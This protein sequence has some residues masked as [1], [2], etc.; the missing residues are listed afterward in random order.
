MLFFFS[1]ISRYD[2]FLQICRRAKEKDNFFFNRFLIA[3][4]YA[5]LARFPLAPR[6]ID[7]IP[8]KWIIPWRDVVSKKKNTDNRVANPF[9]F[10]HP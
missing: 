10:P 9:E 8:D 1:W 2:F 3:I 4:Y 7:P 6:L 5:L